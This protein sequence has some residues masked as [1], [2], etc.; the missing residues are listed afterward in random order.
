MGP[1]FIKEGKVQSLDSTFRGDVPEGSVP[2]ERVPKE[3]VPGSYSWFKEEDSVPMEEVSKE[4][5]QSSDSGFREEDFVPEEDVPKEEFPSSDSGFREE[6]FVPIE[7]VPKEQVPSSDSGFRE[8]DFEKVPRVDVPKE[9]VPM[10]EFPSSDSGFWKEDFVPKEEVFSQTVYWI[11]WIEGNKS[12]L[13]EIKTQPWFYDLKVNWNEYQR[14]AKHNEL[15]DDNN[16]SFSEKKEL[17]WRTSVGKQ[18]NIMEWNSQT[19]DWFKHLLN[20]VQEIPNELESAEIEQQYL[21]KESYRNN[22]L[23][24]KLWMLILALVFEECE[25]EENVCN[26]ELYLDHLLQNV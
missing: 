7:G 18:Y 21:C 4:Q 15:R 1:E 23:A 24:P 2:K 5:V 11:N 6:N 20:N 22:R 17:L 3:Q 25:R 9:N 10:E 26:K 19:A 14:G 13:E 12:V 8:K 16:F